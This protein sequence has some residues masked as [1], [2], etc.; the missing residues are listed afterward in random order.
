[1]STQ[2]AWRNPKRSMITVTAVACGVSAILFLF[3]FNDG[4]LEDMRRNTIELMTGHFQVMPKNYDT[5]VFKWGKI[6]DAGRLRKVLEQDAR[7]ASV[8]PRV[9]TQALVGNEERIHGVMLYGVRPKLEAKMTRLKEKIKQGAFFSGSDREILIGKRLA[10]RLMV[11]PGDYLVV[12]AKDQYG[13]SM[14]YNCRLQGIFHSGYRVMDERVVYVNLETAQDLLGWEGEF[15]NLMVM[16]HGREDIPAVRMD[17]SQHLLGTANKVL[18]WEELTPTV[19][20]WALWAERSMGF[21]M[22]V[23]LVV[24]AIGMMNAVLMSVLE[25][26]RELGVLIALGL[27]PARM[28]AMVLVETAILAFAGCSLGLLLGSVILMYFGHAG[29]SLTNVAYALEASF[30]SPIVYPVF[31]WRRAM[32]SIGLLMGLSLI[33]ALYPAWKAARLDPVQAIYHS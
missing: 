3:G 6:E 8:A 11:H 28:I 10:K 13:V 21:I 2:N 33:A 32:G 26:T 22:W 15:N 31:E 20:Q 29:I 14:G 19:H 23:V 27:S 9:F 1:M 5:E 4:T 18:D 17:L 30:M 24:V 25:R 16:L 7:V 12:M